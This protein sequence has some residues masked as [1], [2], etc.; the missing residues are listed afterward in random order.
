MYL[1]ACLQLC[2]ACE[3]KAAR[4]AKSADQCRLQPP[5]T[6]LVYNVVYVILLNSTTTY[7]PIVMVAND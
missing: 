2:C 4:A 7:V 3:L 1:Q 6:R 5:R